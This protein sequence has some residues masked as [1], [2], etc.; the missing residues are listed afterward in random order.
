MLR[1]LNADYV[2]HHLGL[3]LITAAFMYLLIC[4]LSGC[5]LV[6]PPAFFILYS[7]GGYLLMHEMYAK[8]KRYD[9]YVLEYIGAAISMYLGM[10]LI[11]RG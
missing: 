7:V 2:H 5:K 3:L 9:I 4:Y 1:L 10:S 6:V 8:Q 11:A